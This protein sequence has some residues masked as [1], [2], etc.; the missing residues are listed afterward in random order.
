MRFADTALLKKM[1]EKRYPRQA[2]EEG[3][4]KVPDDLILENDFLRHNIRQRDAEGMEPIHWAA[5]RGD[6]G[7]IDLLIDEGASPNALESKYQQTPLII[8]AIAGNEAAVQR[9]IF[10]QADMNI[11][12]A[13]GKSA[14]FY[15][16]VRNHPAVVSQLL[17]SGADPDVRESKGGITAA[18]IAA[19]MNRPTILAAL[20]D[21]GADVT[22]QDF[23]GLAALDWAAYGG[24]M[25]TIEVLWDKSSV[26]YS[27]NKR[28]VQSALRIARDSGNT[29]VIEYLERLAR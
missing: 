19:Y 8:A 24:N 1:I 18:S 17:K 28:L 13:E 23:Q 26:L 16:I 12:D 14:L 21:A 7:I 25:E 5:A 20:I 22:K 9:L 6:P 11:R 27:S 4:W 29:Q 2:N 15:A 10:H 3:R